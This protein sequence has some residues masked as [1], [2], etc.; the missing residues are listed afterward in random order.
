MQ[1]NKAEFAAAYGSFSQIPACS[2]MEIAF[3]GR[4]NV[5]KSTLIN[6]IFNRKNLARVSA[7]PGKTAT[8]NFYQ[9]EHVYFVD[10]PG[11]GYA[12]VAKSEKERWAGLIEGY[13]NSERDIRLIFLLIDMRHAPSADDLHMIDYLVEAELPFVVI[14]T[15]ADKLKKMARQA[16][17]EAFAQEIPYFSELTVIPFSSQTFEGVEQVRQIITELAEEGD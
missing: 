12:K 5:G 2:R 6:K 17:M 3:A 9:L 7:V 14:L 13:L 10:L 15:K 1:F 8:I 11:Y 16:R 4:S